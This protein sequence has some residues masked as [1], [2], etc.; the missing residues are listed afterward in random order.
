MNPFRW[1]DSKRVPT[2]GYKGPHFWSCAP[3][4][5]IFTVLILQILLLSPSASLSEPTWDSL[6]WPSR[7][8]ERAS[9]TS[10]HATWIIPWAFCCARLNARWTCL[11]AWRPSTCHCGRASR[12][13]CS[14]LASWCTCSTGS[15]HPDYPWDPFPRQRCTTPCGLC[16]APLSN[17]VSKQTGWREGEAWEVKQKTN[18][19][20][21]MNECLDG[22]IR[23]EEV[24]MD[25]YS[26]CS[27]TAN[28]GWSIN[29]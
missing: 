3:H 27:G 29:M 21:W 9:W 26:R 12:A 13:P 22:W 16:M 23:L 17:K 28:T 20:E 1:W 18:V 24:M 19:K 10:P 4:L 8:S 11:P 14:S 5:H 7:L 25:T 15:T 6:P 2:S